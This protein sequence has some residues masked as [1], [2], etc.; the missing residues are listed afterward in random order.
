MY[1]FSE[2][3]KVFSKINLNRLM[4][5]VFR[6]EVIKNELIETVHLRLENDGITANGETLRTDSAIEQ[7]QGKVYSIFNEEKANNRVV[8]LLDTGSFYSSFEVKAKK[9]EFEMSANF[10]KPGNENI[11]D[12]FSFSFAQK[13]FETEILSPTI[14]KYFSDFAN[15][16]VIPVFFDVLGKYMME[17]LSKIKPR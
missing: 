17:S 14:D 6:D 11:A 16:D 1:V 13:E 15:E 8:D 9:S 4:V 10:E 2:I 12:N 3:A 5:E 7:N